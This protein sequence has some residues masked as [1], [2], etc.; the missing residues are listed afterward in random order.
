MIRRIGTGRVAEEIGVGREDHEPERLV[1]GISFGANGWRIGEKVAAAIE[2]GETP[3]AAHDSGFREAT[4]RMPGSI[5][6]DLGEGPVLLLRDGFQP[7]I[8][9]VRELDLNPGDD[10]RFTSALN[11][12][13]AVNTGC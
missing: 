6:H 7:L 8:K 3:R 10:V 11:R 12:G 4:H 5:T 1:D 9:Q 13:Q 2:G